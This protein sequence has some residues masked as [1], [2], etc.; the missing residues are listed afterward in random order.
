MFVH[1]LLTP[2]NSPVILVNHRPQMLF[3]ITN[4]DRLILV[5]DTVR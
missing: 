2:E 5:N 3:G 1:S 4:I